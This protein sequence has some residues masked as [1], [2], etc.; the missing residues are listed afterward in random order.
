MNKKQIIIYLLVGAFC[1][2]L[3]FG[4]AKLTT[5]KQ[6][7]Q[8]QFG[9]RGMNAGLPNRQSMGQRQ[10]GMNGGFN[11]GEIIKIENDKI[12]IKLQNGSTKIIMAGGSTQI[13]K[14]NPGNISD[15]TIG[16]NIMVTGE[17]AAEGIVNAKTIQ[18]RPTIEIQ[19]PKN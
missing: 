12:T 17:S 7:N 3:G 14:S 4:L 10:M 19:K 16:Q 9:A 18:I 5:K 2:L 1:L 11:S 13:M 15:L 6:N 8:N